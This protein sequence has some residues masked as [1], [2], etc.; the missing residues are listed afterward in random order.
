MTTHDRF[1]AILGD[2]YSDYHWQQ[3]VA[4]LRDSYESAPHQ[5][6]DETDEEFRLI[7]QEF[8]AS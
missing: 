3:F 5:L 7:V 2:R 4:W 8:W 6:A 1:K